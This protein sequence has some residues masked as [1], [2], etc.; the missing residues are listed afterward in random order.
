MAT[1]T[2]L[3]KT[4]QQKK[5]GTY[6]VVLRIAHQG[7]KR[8]IYTNCSVLE[9]D[10]DPKGMVKSSC[11]DSKRFNALIQ[12]LRSEVMEQITRA[13]LNDQE[14]NLNRLGK[15]TSS[16]SF[17]A[18][19]ENRKDYFQAKGNI[20]MVYKCTADRREIEEVNNGEVFFTDLTP[21]FLKDLELSFRKEGD[22][23]KKGNSQNTVARKFKN[24]RTHYEKAML[25]SLAPF[26]NP[27]KLVKF[28]KE[29]IKRHKLSVEDIKT[30]ERLQ[31]PH[32]SSL[33]L[34]RDLFLF[35][36]YCQGMRFEN[37]LKL[38]K[39]QIVNAK[40]NYQMNKGKKHRSIGLHPKLEM[41]INTYLANHSGRY[42]FPLLEDKEYSPSEFYHAK[43]SKNAEIN[44]LLKIIAAASGLDKNLSFHMAK[45]SFAFISKSKGVDP[46]AMKDALGHSTYAM[47][48]V[49]LK[50]LD[51]DYI[52]NAVRGVFD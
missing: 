11:K 6:P 20:N 7:K 10:W 38:K 25:E 1:V 44:K 51:D 5:D 52:D 14:I 41:I 19:I 39:E 21:D 12:D 4:N 32:S 29:P 50:S 40:I 16:G 34:A 45:H 43:G 30:L 13:E 47:M 49:Y 42:L 48:E 23:G 28:N 8:F 9:K 24:L 27:F 33:T 2:L 22:N 18:Y 36:F 3:L 17:S 31:L 26:P 37:C 46:H 35:S 15:S